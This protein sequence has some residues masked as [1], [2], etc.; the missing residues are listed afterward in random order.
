MFFLSKVTV[1]NLQINIY[2]YIGNM[3]QAIINHS[4]FVFNAGNNTQSKTVHQ[5][6][7]KV[8]SL[9]Q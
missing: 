5:F 2:I 8:H 3:V 9:S 6:N 7:F 4:P 1:L